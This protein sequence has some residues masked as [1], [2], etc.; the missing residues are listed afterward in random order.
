MRALAG[1]RAA[2]ALVVAAAAI[3]SAPAMAA[4]RVPVTV[5]VNRS[6][7]QTT[8]E[9]PD[10]Y[11]CQITTYPSGLADE[12]NCDGTISVVVKFRGRSVFED[13]LDGS[14]D[15]WGGGTS[16]DWRGCRDAGVHDYLVT[17]NGSTQWDTAYG[18]F[19]IPSCHYPRWRHVSYSTA[20]K[21]AIAQHPESELVDAV[22]CAIGGHRSGGSAGIWVCGV[23]SN[24]SWRVCT[25]Y[26]EFFF[27]LAPSDAD[28]FGEG[29]F[30]SL[31]RTDFVSTWRR[32]QCQAL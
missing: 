13:E 23:A 31:E 19:R 3:L 16:Y 28:T 8:F 4:A 1:H 11:H 7:L 22:R 20:A 10:S 6:G 24:N 26:Y 14:G 25:R 5:D 9:I 29:G 2:A 27:V 15:G 30:G 17:W 18:R 21:A 32:T 12:A